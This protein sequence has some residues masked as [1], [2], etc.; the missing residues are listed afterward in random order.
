VKPP[1]LAPLNGC[2]R[3]G[4]WKYKAGASDP[5]GKILKATM[6]AMLEKLL[7]DGSPFLPDRRRGRASADRATFHCDHD[8]PRRIVQ[9]AQPR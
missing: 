9:F 1:I 8:Q 6:V 5:D 2:L 7:A 4:V 3:V